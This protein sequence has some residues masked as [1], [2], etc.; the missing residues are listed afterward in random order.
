[1]DQE[2]RKQHLEKLWGDAAAQAL[3]D[4]V[5]EAAAQANGGL[6][7]TAQHIAY[8]IADQERMA[9]RYRQD[10]EK[11]GVIETW[12]NG[13]QHGIRENKSCAALR[14]CLDLQRKLMSEIKITPSSG[15]TG[16][17]GAGGEFD[18]FG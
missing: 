10:I 5:C 3:Y 16:G 4:R 2:L 18:D 6:S 14:A 7:S 17:S 15:G 13:R 8:Q 11:R 12:Y 1:M 9:N